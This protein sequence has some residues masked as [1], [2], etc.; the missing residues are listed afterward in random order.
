MKKTFTTL[1]VAL[2]LIMPLQSFAQVSCTPVTAGT[3]NFCCGTTATA[4]GDPHAA[5]CRAY[6]NGYS[7]DPAEPSTT[8]TPGTLGSSAGFDNTV[9]NTT[10]PGGSTI[11]ATPV[12][13]SAELA[14][15]SN[16]KFLS[17]LDILIWVKC[18]IV[19][20]IIPLIFALALMFFLWGVMRFVMASDS[21]KKEESKKFIM[22]GLIGL[23]VMTSLWGI[24]KI[25]GTT[26]GIES[27][28]PLL[29]TSAL[30]K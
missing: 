14:Q 1:I 20:A 22:A 23:F 17:L 27:T 13:G 24:I 19:V 30:K 26:L 6:R 11:A 21:T 9:I 18:I 3:Y 7:V 8:Y 5:D 4:A 16:I 28:V 12:A 25:L 29:Q 2:V 10:S 15:C